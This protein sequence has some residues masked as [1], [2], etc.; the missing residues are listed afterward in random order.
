L[1]VSLAV[2]IQRISVAPSVL[3]AFAVSAVH[4]PA[5]V[6]LWLLPLPVVIQAGMTMACAISLIFFMARDA[7]L[8]APGSIIA[9]ELK[10]S[11]SI[12]CQ[13]RNGDWVDCE[14]L[15]STFVSPQMTVV[16]LRPRGRRRSRAVILVPD[17]V[18]HRDF[19]RLRIWLRW[20]GGEDSPS[21][22]LAGR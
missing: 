1:P 12:A 4:V 20:R 22:P 6:I 7:A 9:L 18:D 5:A 21:V 16:N 19:R 17:N 2:F 11:G 3:I 13:T 8:H 15:G 10:E 14:L